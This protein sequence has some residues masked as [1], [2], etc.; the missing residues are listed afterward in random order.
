MTLTRRQFA[1][2]AAAGGGLLVAWYLWPRSYPSPL[3]PG[4]GEHVFGGWLTIARDG[5]VTVAVPQLE[6]GQG[7]NS[8]L[9]QVAAV[10]LG[11]DWRQ[12]AVE[13]APPSGIYG[14]LP[15]AAKWAGLWSSVPSLAD[16]ADDRLTENFARGEMFAAT[17]DGTALEAFELPIRNAAAAA[18]TMLAMAAAERWDIDF[19]ECEVADGFVTYGDERLS[20]GAL[21]EDAAS[22]DPPDPPPLRPQAA[23]EGPIAGEAE[24]QTAFPRLDLPAKV[25]GS[26]LFACDIRLP[27]LVYA[28]IRHGP[29]GQPEL[30]RFDADAVKG[31]RG[32]V[33][34]VRSKRYLAAVAESWWTAEQALKAM[35]P[36]FRGPPGF[37]SAAIEPALEAAFDT[38]EPEAIVSY[39]DPGE[40]LAAPSHTSRY[41]I[42]PAVHASIE[43]ASAT[44]RFADGRLELWIAAQAPELTRRAAAKAIG[45]GARDV[46]LYPTAAGGSFDARLER[47]HAI[48]VAQIAQQIGRPVQLT[49]PRVQEFQ[50]LPPRT[51]VLAEL[52]AAFT[53]GTGGQIAAWRTR[54]AMPATTREFG[55]RLFDNAT[56]ESAIAN[57]AGQADPLACEGAVPPY[58]IANIAVEHLPVTLDLPTGRLRGN[59]A[60]YTAFCT[61]SF[62]DE[63]AEKAGQDPFL[64]RMALLGQ[65]PRMADVLRRATRIGGWDGG[66]RGSSQGL[67]MVRMGSADGGGRIACVAEAALGAGGVQVT[68]LSAAVDIGRIVNIDLARQQIEGG[69]IFGLSQATGSSAAFKDGKP[70]PRS[71]R[72]LSLPVLAD[73]PEVIVDFVASEA[74][75]FD[76]G[77]LG[78]AVAAPAIANALYSATGRR[79]RRLPLLSER[80]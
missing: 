19:E 13:P 72:G 73:C 69:L 75:P 65:A 17:A 64:Y 25:D 74:A 12:I 11:A 20:F 48:E 47:L 68:R 37:D 80:Q 44:A 49:W 29:L 22:Y 60:A 54:L 41:M 23:S 78:V 62:L 9:A 28:S 1:V 4:P 45:I 59:S 61:E 79:F 24:A 27:G 5:V 6:M 7:V 50:S 26:F 57:A 39:G 52:A 40:L 66:R 70:V 58:A 53:P 38:V 71:L 10:E 35:R 46:V 56:P 51:P 3:S 32:V 14:N 15:L 77:E 31:M 34:V 18:R 21:V 67:A 8:L 2:G 30:S 33:G 43:T 16:E 55:A 76:P 36:V 42:A 63:L